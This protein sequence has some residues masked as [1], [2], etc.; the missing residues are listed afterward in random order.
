MSWESNKF[1]I[2]LAN[3]D[4]SERAMERHGADVECCGSTVHCQ[5]VAI[6]LLVTCDDTGLN[7]NFVIEASWEKR[8]NRTVHQSAAERFFG[9]RSAFSFQESTRELA[10]GGESFAI[11]TREREKIDSR[12]RGSGRT[13]DEN[14]G[15]TVLDQHGPSG[16]LG[17]LAGFERQHLSSNLLLYSNFVRRHF[18]LPSFTTYIYNYNYSPREHTYQAWV[19]DKIT[20]G[21]SVPKTSVRDEREPNREESQHRK[22]ACDSC[23]NSTQT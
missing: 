18:I 22:D 10:S 8:A 20:S 3:A 5:H 9:A 7:L 2:D 12:T 15:F 21:D 6:V 16:L 19:R 23:E 17:Q 4:G 11:I 13:G 14:N 1:A